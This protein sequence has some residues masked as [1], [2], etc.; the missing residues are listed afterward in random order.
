[1]TSQTLGHYRILE[2][3]GA[4][5]M[6][7]VY[8][9]VDTHLD[10]FV[11][12]KVLPPE[13]VADAERKRRFVQEAKAASALN[14]P[15]IITIHDIANENGI[16]FIAMEYVHGKALNEL[17]P[18]KGL[19]L[20]ESL[21]YAI[22]IAD[23]LAAAHAAGII[24]RDL[25]PG[26]VM[27]SGAEGRSGLIKVLDFGLAKLTDKT[28]GVQLEFTETIRQ[29][30]P[31]ST[32][33]GVIVGTISYMSPEQAE[34]KQVDAR[35]DI[36]SFGALLY[37]MVTG[38]RAFQGAS[39]LSTLS[40]IL[41]E[42]PKPA[43]QVV[44]GL[45]RELER[46]IARCLRKS[47]ERRFQDMPDLKVALEELKEE[48]DSGKLT[49]FPPP[50]GVRRRAGPMLLLGVVVVL[51]AVAASWF[52]W[53]SNPGKPTLRPL[54]RLTSTGAAIYPAI[55]PDG[56]LLAYQSSVGGLDPDI[57]IQQIGGGKA[58]QITHE[59]GGATA[60]VL[61]PDGTQVVFES[62][63]GIY[64]V[65]ALGGPPRLITSDGFAPL[66]T[67]D[68][69]AI[70][71]LRNLQVRTGLFMVPNQ[72]GNETAIQPE[73]RLYS[74]QVLSPDGSRM[75][76]VGSRNG[77]AQ[78][79]THWW[80]IPIASG[81]L[82]EMA[83]PSLLSGETQAPPPL[84]WM[85]AEKDSRQWVIFG[86]PDGDTYNLFRVSV[87]NGRKA[88]EPEQITYTTGLSFGPSISDTGRM[89]FASGTGTTNLWSIPTDT[90][91]A[92][93]TGE[94][95]SLTQ[96]EGVI[97]DSPTL[98]RDGNMVAFFSGNRLIAKDLTSGR[99]TLLVPDLAIQRGDAPSISPDGT[100]VVYYRA[101]QGESD[102]Y[103]IP[104]AGGAPRR[105]CQKCGVPGGF[106]SDGRRLLTSY[107]GAAPTVRVGLVELSTGRFTGALRDPKYNVFNPY[108]SWDDKWMAFLMQTANRE[109][110]RIYVTPV[111]NYIP[112]GPDRWVQLTS[113]EY[114][115]DK[116][117]FS[118]DGNTM[119]FT[120]N[121]DGSTCL[122]ALRLDPK[123]KRSVGAPFAVQ[124][125]HGS[126]RIYRGISTPNHMEVNIARDKIITNLDEYH[127]DIW[128][129]QL[130]RGK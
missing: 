99:E 118:P 88:S 112:A 82:E 6:G 113:G 50:I 57:W 80:T 28:E 62:R 60:P 100:Q 120:S 9:A 91:R 107:F 63:G 121:R 34:G 101:A 44:E 12:I 122:C 26:N 119:Y 24:H 81:K 65:P 38:Q 108:Y 39:Q 86:L 128:M 61:S 84:A 97:N 14:H 59:K 79:S 49:A 18:R 73:L 56:K 78:D 58:I 5:G 33:E 36:F 3:L 93:A 95:Q 21:K 67:R 32:G 53:R 23:A 40:A 2:Q 43:S 115:D 111:E 10:R 52:W 129:M 30:D 114:Y 66:Y 69:S 130:D 98:S 54:T 85:A 125:F 105:I 104:A 16:D 106:S 4:G 94:R 109:R 116:E 83:A 46:I 124:H 45:P 102:L 123:T 127:T 90:N 75:L 11:A 77:S 87:N 89:V 35:S 68:G 103:V 41:R 8:K 20:S 13:K 74:T 42:E 71:F 70:L 25:K 27:V 55:S 22:Q 76:A 51:G 37:E 48:S 110:L 47:P 96:A 92:H 126:Q 15:N 31:P 19:P 72:G 17:I 29:G 7:I 117:Q 1:M 64:E